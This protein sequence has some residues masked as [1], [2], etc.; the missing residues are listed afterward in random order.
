MENEKPKII[1][2]GAY[3]CVIKPGIDSQGNAYTVPG[4]ISKIEIEKS[5]I[6][7][8]INVS[9]KIKQI[10]DYED[11]FSPIL[12]NAPLELGK[13][14]VKEI[15]DCKI[16]ERIT[17]P[18]STRL[19]INKIK[20]VGKDS[21]EIYLLKMLEENPD[22]FIEMLIDTHIYLLDSLTEL[23]KV[24]IIHNDIKENNILC[25]DESGVPIIID[26]GLSIESEYL[27]LPP[28]ASI[29]GS[30]SQEK[31]GSHIYKYF[32]K[33][34]PSYEVWCIEIHILNYM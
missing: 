2:E 9:N 24:G 15:N 20:Y 10:P 11:R 32:F 31:K 25:R 21:L 5:T 3:G 18:N 12:E 14:N 13:I 1:G 33:Y 30:L 22:K 8:E 29:I 17:E 26:F 23:N 16:V 4:Y 19:E 7:N 27:R 34:E 6:F 28:Q